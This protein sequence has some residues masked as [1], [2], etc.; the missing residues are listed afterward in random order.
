MVEPLSLVGLVGPILTVVQLIRSKA[1]TASQNKYKCLVLAQRVNNLGNIL[2]S[3]SYAAAND[4]ARAH[5]LQNL[6]VALREALRLIMSCQL[7]GM[8]SGKYSRSKAA[9]LDYVDEWI[10]NCIMELNLVTQARAQNRRRNRARAA[11]T[12]GHGNNRSYYQAQEGDYV[13]R[14]WPQKRRSTSTVYY[15]Y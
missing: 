2:P 4:M 8:F 10:D 9:E 7:G 11:G 5:A 1:S 3:F 15:M 13:V 14:S 12:R 6:N